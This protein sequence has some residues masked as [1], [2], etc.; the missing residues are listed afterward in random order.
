MNSNGPERAAHELGVVGVQVA[1]NAHRRDALVQSQPKR[2]IG[3]FPEEH[4]VALLQLGPPDYERLTG[5]AAGPDGDQAG[6]I[7][8]ASDHLRDRPVS[9]VLLGGDRNQVEI[10][11]AT[12]MPWVQPMAIE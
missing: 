7:D 3:P 8:L 9:Q 4:I 12:D 5:G 11:D 10:D 2:L 1:G 6:R